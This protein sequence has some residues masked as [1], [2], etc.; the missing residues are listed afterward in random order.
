MKFE[1][2]IVTSAESYDDDE[3]MLNELGAEGWELTA[4]LTSEVPYLDEEGGGD[5]DEEMISDEMVTEVVYYLKRQG[6]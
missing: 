5:D 3:A 6:A 2:K 4:V 1:Y